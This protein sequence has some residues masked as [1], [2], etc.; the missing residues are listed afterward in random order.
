MY[1]TVLSAEQPLR[2]LRLSWLYR[3]TCIQWLH[4]ALLHVYL[5]TF[6]GQTVYTTLSCLGTCGSVSHLC[7]RWQVFYQA[8][9]CPPLS[10]R[11]L[12]VYRNLSTCLPAQVTLVLGSQ[13][14]ILM[15]HCLPTSNCR[16]CG[17]VLSSLLT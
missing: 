1:K 3:P 7:G 4:C 5:Y 12:F 17:V 6:N 15:V 9:A 8:L 14:N 13:K 16:S 10:P 11:P 2:S